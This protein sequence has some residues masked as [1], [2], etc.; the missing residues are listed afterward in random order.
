MARFL[1]Y[2]RELGGAAG[3]VTAMSNW[4]TLATNLNITTE[5]IQANDATQFQQGQVAFFANVP[6]ENI[7]FFKQEMGSWSLS[8]VFAYTMVDAVS[9]DTNSGTVV[10][11]DGTVTTTN[12]GA[13]GGANGGETTDTTGTGSGTSTGGGTTTT[14]SPTPTFSFSGGVK[15][16]AVVGLIAVAAFGAFWL[17]KRRD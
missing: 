2:E 16:A 10:G 5:S 8:R 6:D 17:G 7:E 15:I 4:E 9:T 1:V 14:P 13:N 11:A 3:G 12:G